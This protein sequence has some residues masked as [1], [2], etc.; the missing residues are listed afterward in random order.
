MGLD[1]AA[2]KLP[3]ELSG[4][5]RKRAA[6][7][8]A[9]ALDP[10]LLFC[11]E[12]SAGLDPITAAALDRLILRMRDVPYIDA[13]AVGALEELAARCRKH[14]CR[15][16]MSGLQPQPRRTLHS[17]GFLKHHRVLL[18]SNSYMALERAKAI[19]VGTDGR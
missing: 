1:H 4:G 10:D 6:L 16:V 17:F 19:V 15:I 11:D 14:G 12:P 3:S 13:T 2:L 18:A 8:R 9:I 5:M 7:A